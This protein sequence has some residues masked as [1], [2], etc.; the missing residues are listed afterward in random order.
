MTNEKDGKTVVRLRVNGSGSDWRLLAC[1]YDGNRLVWVQAWETTFESKAEAE[2]EARAYAAHMNRPAA[3][4]S[5]SSI[6]YLYDGEMPADIYYDH[7]FGNP[8]A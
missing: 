2:S 4:E 1:T 5:G 3:S 7:Y 6:L 8:L